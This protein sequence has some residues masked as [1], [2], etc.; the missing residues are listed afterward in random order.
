MLPGINAAL[1]SYY[2]KWKT[3]VDGRTNA[4]FFET[5]KPVAV[6]W[7]VAD[8]DAYNHAYQELKGQC[9]YIVETW[10][11]DRWI[12]KMHLKDTTA[13]GGIALV[14]LMQ[15]RPGADDP[16]G[17]DHVDFYSTEAVNAETVLSEEPKLQWSKE[18]NDAIEEYSWIS[19]W[20]DD[21]E[22]KIK[23]ST[24]LDIITK[25]LT[26]INASIK[27]TAKS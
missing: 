15:R 20:F 10:M 1:N 22:A 13:N 19:I 2:S 21:T 5:L 16:L 6:G 3:L 24:V 23:S 11:N 25:E 14:K 9:D 27:G 26:T 8:T 4:I 7:K 18:S 12:A 17:L